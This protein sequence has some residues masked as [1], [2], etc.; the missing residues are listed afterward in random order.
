MNTQNQQHIS[1]VVKLFEW[2]VN[3]SITLAE[4]SSLSK[5]YDNHPWFQNKDKHLL[6]YK[7]LKHF[8]FINFSFQQ[9]SFSGNRKT[10][11]S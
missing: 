9:T 1:W 3:L 6:S 2:S 11:S 10:S 7:A 4:L 8:I 5:G